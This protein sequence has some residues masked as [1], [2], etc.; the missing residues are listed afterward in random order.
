MM[1]REDIIE[2]ANRDW[3]RAERAK[4]QYWVER[5]KQMTPQEVLAL[6]DDLRASVIARRPDWPSEEERRLDLETHARVSEMLQSVR[7]S[8]GR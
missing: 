3:R 7:I 4:E 2:Y 6:V 5:K 8:R 1:R